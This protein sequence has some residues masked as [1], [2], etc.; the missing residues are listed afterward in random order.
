MNHNG[1]RLISS[2]NGKEEGGGQAPLLRRRASYGV[3]RMRLN[4]MMNAIVVPIYPPFEEFD[5]GA[6]NN[7]LRLLILSP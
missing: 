7:L 2:V 5:F 6:A 3:E 1:M 4:R